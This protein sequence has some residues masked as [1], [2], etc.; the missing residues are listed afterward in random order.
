MLGYYYCLFC[1]TTATMGL[2][3]IINPVLR[4]VSK[5]TPDCVT[6]ENPFIT[7]TVF[8]AAA[9]LLA[10]ILFFALIVPSIKYKFIES[11]ADG[12]ISSN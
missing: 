2:W 1:V 9:L 12:I 4:I 10:P 6:V 8:F 11:M 7:Y 3:E 5:E